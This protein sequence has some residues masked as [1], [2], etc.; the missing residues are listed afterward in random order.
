MKEIVIRTDEDKFFKQILKILH[1]M[2]PMNKLRPKQLEVLGEILYQQNKY[3]A[4]D[5]KDRN[6]L[7]FST[8]GRKE[9][10]ERLGMDINVFNNNISML[11]KNGMLNED[12][13][14]KKFFSNIVFDGMFNLTFMFKEYD[15]K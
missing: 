7:I 4:I 14:L 11:K 12:N 2:P 13:S 10:R 9:M 3:K 15:G 5:E 6:N 8:G 1:G